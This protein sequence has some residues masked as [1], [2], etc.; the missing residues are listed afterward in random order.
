MAIASKND[1]ELVRQALTE[2]SGVRL[3]IDDFAVIVANWDPKPGNV[4]GIAQALNIGVDSLVFVDDN[5]SGGGRCVPRIRRSAPSRPIP[6][7]RHGPFRP[8]YA[9]A[10]SPPFG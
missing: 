7:T 10:S 2:H 1:D 4:A 3:G 8:Y 6:T 5:A 9:M